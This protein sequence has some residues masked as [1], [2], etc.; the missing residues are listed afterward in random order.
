MEWLASSRR[1]ADLARASGPLYGKRFVERL[2][3]WC[4]MLPTDASAVMVGGMSVEATNGIVPQSCPDCGCS[5]VPCCDHILWGCDSYGCFRTIARP[6]HPLEARLGWCMD[7]PPCDL[8][9]DEAGHFRA[10][11]V[12]MGHIRAAET[13]RRHKRWVEA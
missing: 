11:L 7:I 5:V 3:K 10:R 6:D 4:M 1:D 13:A 2:H 12:Q 9:K 8:R